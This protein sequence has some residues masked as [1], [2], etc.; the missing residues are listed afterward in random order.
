MYNIIGALLDKYPEVSILRIYG[1]KIEDIDFSGLGD[2]IPMLAKRNILFRN[3]EDVSRVLERLKEYSLHF[4]IRDTSNKK[5]EISEFVKYEN[6]LLNNK[7]QLRLLE[8]HKESQKISNKYFALK[9]RAETVVIKEA[10]VI[11][12]TCAGAGSNRMKTREVKQCI[13]D[14]CAM[15]IEPETLLPM[16]LSEKI[17]LVGDHKQLQ[18]VVLNKTAQYLGLNI[19][20]FQRLFEDQRISRYCTMLT[21]QYRMVSL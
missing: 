17:I 19:S 14:E 1:T 5:V 2:I 12:C 3:D 11:F 9:Q 4:K 18:P 15:C 21:E 8:D 10:Q 13:I 16:I 20:M 7:A 6:E